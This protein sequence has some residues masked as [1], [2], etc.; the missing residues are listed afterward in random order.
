MA[1]SQFS[2]GA[3]AQYR[4][5]GEQLPV[6]GGF[7]ESGALTHDPAAIE[8]SGR[9]LPIGFW[10]G[11]GL[12]IVLDLIAATLSGGRATHEIPPRAEEETGQ[13]V[14][15]IGMSDHVRRAEEYAA[16]I[17]AGD[18]PACGLVQLACERHLRD[19][20]NSG[21]PYYLDDAAASRVCQ[22]I[23]LLPHVKGKWA[24]ANERLT[25][26]PWQSFI[27][28]NVFGWKRKSDGLRRYRRVYIEVPRKNGKSSLTAAVGLY[29]LTADGEH[30]AEIYSGAT[31]E[32]QAW[33]VFG[34]ARLMARNSPALVD[35]FDLAVGAKNLHILDS[36][37][38]FEP[39]I[40]KPGDGASPSMSITDEYH[41]HQTSEQYDTMLTGMGARE[42]PLAW[43][44]TTAGSDTAGPCYALRG[45]AIET[46]EGS[47]SNDELFALIAP[48]VDRD[49]SD[50]S[51]IETSV[52]LLGTYELAHQPQ[53]PGPRPSPAAN[54]LLHRTRSVRA[55]PA[56]VR[57]VPAR[58][59]ARH[60]CKSFPTT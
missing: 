36:A 45:E 26:S 12:A 50:L 11:S 54:R 40:G 6:A 18:M 3:L 8:R 32:K 24:R 9:A 41:E 2:F 34:P 37:S 35:H 10:K 43:V 16:E 28:V 56:P 7:D 17:V 48:H 38:K 42:Q 55:R 15:E 53:T 33:E 1:M 31:T 49:L 27:I 4:M 57:S 23:E 58:A 19:T 21:S 20:R 22:F 52:L 13:S 29:M 60:S 25:L 51:P 14:R 5:R 44:I 59:A 30:G 46:L 39:V 47:I